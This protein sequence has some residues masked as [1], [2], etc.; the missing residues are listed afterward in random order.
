MADIDLFA[1]TNLKLHCL[2]IE[3]PHQPAANI[4]LKVVSL[5]IQKT[6]E[7]FC[8]YLTFKIVW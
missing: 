3:L 8:D 6:P 2:W 1:A 4:P 5:E 7:T